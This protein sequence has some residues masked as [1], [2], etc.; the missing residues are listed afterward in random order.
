MK[1]KKE[2][3]SLACDPG[4][5]KGHAIAVFDDVCLESVQMVQDFGKWA[6]EFSKDFEVD[7]L[8]LELPVVRQARLQKG[9]QSDIVN[10]AAAAGGVV[11]TCILLWP[12]CAATMYKPEEWKGQL[13]KKIACD[14]IKDRLT[15][16][17]KLRLPKRL[18]HD[19][20]DA[21]GIGFHCFDRARSLK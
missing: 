11:S 10:L 20:L 17:E 6:T 9:R 16:M 13:P 21:I 4:V 12:D 15:I 19:M 3:R 1:K 2:R 8:A 5:T 14:R 7:E 18:S